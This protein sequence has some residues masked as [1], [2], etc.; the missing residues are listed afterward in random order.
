MAKMV[1]NGLSI[2]QDNSII[3]KFKIG[4][5]LLTSFLLFASCKQDSKPTVVAKKPSVKIPVFQ[6]DSAYAHIEKQLSF[7]PRNPGS[8]GHR[9]CRKWF[10]DKFQSYGAE[11]IEQD[12]TAN[13]YTGE[14]FPA[15][16]IIA[17][18]NPSKKQRI[19]LSAHWDTRFIGEEDNSRSMRD[20]PIP[21][22]DDGASG[23]AVLIEIARILNEQ[24]IDLGVDIIL[25]DAEDQGKRGSNKTALWCLGSQYWS[26]NIH[27]RGY[28]AK[29][30]INLDM[31]GAKNPRFGYE[32][33]SKKYA[34]ALQTKIWKLAQGMGYSDMFVSENTSYVTDDHQFVNELANIPMVDIINQ[35]PHTE[36][37]FMSAWHTHDDDISIIDKRSLQV[38]GQVV[39]ATI[40]KESDGSL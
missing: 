1:H 26:R 17:Q 24:K 20:K 12:F 7:G 25:W 32:G 6:Q 33:F 2:N 37:K 13:L 18:Y 35:P 23:C 29:W 27:K 5:F 22:A 19:I 3:M 39:T 16:N 28:R 14:S 8:E 40:Y 30:G 31:I 4:F 15:A 11:V 36:T 21:G 38:V 34:G 9:A 10:V